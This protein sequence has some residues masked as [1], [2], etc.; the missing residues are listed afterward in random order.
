MIR[1]ANRTRFHLKTS[2]G[3]PNAQRIFEPP[4]N[5]N[6]LPSSIESVACA[7]NSRGSTPPIATSAPLAISRP[8]RV[9]LATSYG[10]GAPSASSAA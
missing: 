2:N 6:F 5:V 3:P 7:S 8:G 9:S 4:A 1:P 10:E